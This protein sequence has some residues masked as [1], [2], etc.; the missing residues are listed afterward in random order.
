MVK[1]SRASRSGAWRTK[2]ERHERRCS[3][4]RHPTGAM[5]SGRGT[6]RHRGAGASRV[7]LPHWPLSSWCVLLTESNGSQRARAPS[8]AVLKVSLLGH[9]AGGE[10]W[11]GDPEEHNGHE[12][13]NELTSQGVWGK[14]LLWG[15]GIISI[16]HTGKG[17]ASEDLR[18]KMLTTR[19]QHG[20]TKKRDGLPVARFFCRGPG[21]PKFAG[22][23][24]FQQ[25]RNLMALVRTMRAGRPQKCNGWG[26]A[27]WLIWQCW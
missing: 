2:W 21:I 8:D 19:N 18:K 13:H 17:M 6:E 23:I 9:R 5:A 14:L 22:G 20:L 27:K 16:L 15:S 10:G 7:I 12:Q 24:A 26:C 1:A 3:G 25:S 11:R 4:K